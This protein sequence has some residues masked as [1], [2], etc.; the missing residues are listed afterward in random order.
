VDV[1][2]DKKILEKAA[3]AHP[4]FLGDVG[5]QEEAIREELGFKDAPVPF[6]EPKM[7]KA[8]KHPVVKQVRVFRMETAAQ[9]KKRAAAK[10]KRKDTKKAKRKG[11]K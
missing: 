1:D 4:E 7:Q 9:E 6:D 8:L 3:K 11:R 5:K 10:K 2:F